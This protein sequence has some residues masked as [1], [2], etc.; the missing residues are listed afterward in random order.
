LRLAENSVDHRKGVRI[1]LEIQEKALHWLDPD[2]MKQVFWNL[3][4]NAFQSM[5]EGGTLSISIK[6][7]ARRRTK[8]GDRRSDTLSIR[9]E[10]T[11]EG[12]PKENLEKV[13]RPFFTTKSQ[14][15]GL[16]L[17]IVQRIV[18]E[19]GGRVKVESHARRTA[20]TIYLPLQ[21]KWA[22]G[23]SDEGLPEKSERVRPVL[24]REGR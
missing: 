20:F 19:H 8:S 4:V 17:A 5:P 1:R 14:G 12:I 7:L 22:P 2:Q 21:E 16:G 3:I 10:D 15:S 18:E 24:S 9:F 23:E 6:S 11:G 13:F